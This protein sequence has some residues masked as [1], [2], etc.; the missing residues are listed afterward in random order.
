MPQRSETD[1]IYKNNPSQYIHCEGL[2]IE[3]AIVVPLEN[4]CVDILPYSKI[5]FLSANCMVVEGTLPDDF[6]AFFRREG[7]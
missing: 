2:F 6:T 5:I 1:S 3:E 4:I 7:F